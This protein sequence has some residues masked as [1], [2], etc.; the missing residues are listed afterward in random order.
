MTKDTKLIQAILFWR[1]EPISIK[2]LSEMTKLSNDVILESI[3]QIEDQLGDSGLRL[4][5]K[6]DEVVMSTNPE[7][8]SEISALT[9][10]ELTR[11][12]GKAG[13]ETLAI[14]LYRSPVSRAD[15]D[16]IRGVNSTFILRNLS[17]RGLVERFPDPKDERRF[18][19][20]SSFDLLAL[21]GVTKIED[22]PDYQKVLEELRNFE[23]SEKESA[24]DVKPEEMQSA[25]EDENA[26]ENDGVEI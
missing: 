14:V 23:A 26:I 4:V 10:E 17:I 5:R 25:P 2:R 8:G 15:I 9:K 1:G 3:T 6:G 24:V 21:L 13:L 20:Q 16:Y 11:D 7:V 18:L 12:L 19:Y 22:L